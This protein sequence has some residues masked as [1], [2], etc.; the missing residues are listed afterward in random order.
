LVRGGWV[1]LIERDRGV[2][3]RF[4]PVGPGIDALSARLRAWRA[5]GATG[6]SGGFGLVGGWAWILVNEQAVADR[7]SGVAP[8]SSTHMAAEVTAATEGLAYLVASGVREVQVVSDSKYLV[9]GMSSNGRTGW[10]HAAAEREW[11]SARGKPLA[12]RNLWER[13]LELEEC[14]AVTWRWAK[15]L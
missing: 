8:G 5:V 15:P 9:N 14:L 3:G 11:R 1:G 13:L 2:W 12:N 10:A 4:R 7:G 6:W